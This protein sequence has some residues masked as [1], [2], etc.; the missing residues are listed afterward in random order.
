MDKEIIGKLDQFFAKYKSTTFKKKSAIIILAD[1][2]DGV[3]FLREGYVKMNTILAN[4]NELILNIYKPGSFFPMFWALGEVPNNYGFE[5]ITNVK[6]YKAP[7]KEVVNY[8]KENPEVSFD[9]TK[10]ILAGVDGL[11]T[12]YNHLLV[13]NS[14]SRVASAL[15]IASKRF[16]VPT[17]DEKTLINLKLTHQDIANLAGISRETASIAIEGLLKRKI[18]EQRKRSFVVMDVGK[19]TNETAID[20]DSFN[21]PTVL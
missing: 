5:A 12:N 2:P 9:L 21:S 8:L 20:G 13:G 6:L 1:E 3:Y 10:R 15:L 11:L 17:Q 14:N 4:G 19:L 7:R 16:G 18:I